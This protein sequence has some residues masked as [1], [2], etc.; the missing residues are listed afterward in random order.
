MCG[1]EGGRGGKKCSWNV[2]GTANIFTE[3]NH[4]DQAE[5]VLLS[6]LRLLPLLDTDTHFITR[7]C[8]WLGL[9]CIFCQPGPSQLNLKQLC[10]VVICNSC[11]AWVVAQKKALWT[12]GKCLFYL[13][14]DS[15]IWPKPTIHQSR[16]MAWF[17]PGWRL[18]SNQR[19][20]FNDLHSTP[21]V[22]CLL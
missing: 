19:Q 17:V 2:S 22:I 21:D 8:P 10:K 18:S 4:Y 11:R 6:L 9:L 7:A 14:W 12:K 20:W 3:P 1:T 15:V 13:I 16:C 5:Y